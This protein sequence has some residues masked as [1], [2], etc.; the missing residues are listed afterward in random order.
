MAIDLTGKRIIVTGA[1]GAIG[2]AAARLFSKKGARV[3]AVDIDEA[4]LKLLD[5]VAETH[6]A[7]VRVDK[8]VAGYVARA[9]ELF[10]G[11][12]GLFN[13]AGIEGSVAPSGST[14]S[15]GSTPSSPPTSGA[16]SSG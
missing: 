12:D 16:S 14:P 9:V 2:S 3:L 6:V 5:G 11:A 1:A 15:T 4:G 8:Q 10:G 13:N 7:D